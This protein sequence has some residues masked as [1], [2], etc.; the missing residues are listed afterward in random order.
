VCILFADITGFTRLVES[1]EPEVVYDIVRPLMDVLVALIRRHGGDIQQVLGDGFMSVFGLRVTRGDEV[2][3]AV[4]AGLALA[5]TGGTGAGLVV[6]G[7]HPPVHVGIEFGEVLVTP[8]WE[9]SGFGVW[10]RPVNLA[11]RLCELAG[12]GEVQLGPAAFGRVGQS[13]CPA[14]AAQ[15]WL[16]GISGP[17]VAHRLALDLPAALAP[18]G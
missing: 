14:T 6:G 1:V 11:R 15:A 2:E 10:G 17:V 12:P 13:I 18:G 7:S 9:P 5:A 3:R 16:K 4:L 8:S